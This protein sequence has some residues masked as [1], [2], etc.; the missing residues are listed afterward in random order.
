MEKLIIAYGGGVNSTA[1]LVAFQERGIVPHATL[2]ADTGAEEPHTYAHIEIVSEWCQDNG[3]PPV[4]VVKTTT[5]DGNLLT[6]EQDCLRRKALPSLAYGFKSCSERFKIRPQRKRI[7][8]D[9]VIQREWAKGNRVLNAIG[10]DYGENTRR[11]LDLSEDLKTEYWYPLDD[12]KWARVECVAA[13]C[14]AGLPQPGKSACFFCPA[15]KPAEIVR[16]ARDYPE[17]MERALAIEANAVTYPSIKGLGRSFAWAEV[18]K[19]GEMFDMGLSDW[20]I[21]CEC[22]NS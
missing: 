3:M 14:K 12:Y 5:K 9:P 16:L 8:L 7:K 17:L 15:T 11:R 19:Q 1:M 4:E 2:F 13:I 20:Q 6:L 21:P 10:L 22:F 18:L